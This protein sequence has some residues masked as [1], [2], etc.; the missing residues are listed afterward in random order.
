MRPVRALGVLLLALTASCL[1]RSDPVVL[2][3][4]R[5]LSPAR[6]GAPAAAPALE[7][8]PVRL[9]EALQ[10]TQLVTEAGAGALAI[11]ERHRWANGLDR[12]V[13][14]VLAENLA[15]LLGSEA[16]VPF[17]DGERVKAAWRLELDVQRLDG[18]P[19]GTLMLRA[20]WMLVP[21]KGGAAA[22]RRRVSLD[23]PVGG[24][25]LESLAAAHDRILDRLSREIAA[26]AASWPSGPAPAAR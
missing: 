14:R 11:S 24:P 25:G 22:V 15:A 2:H 8:M 23:E 9:P 1:R 20:T 21:A 16:V 5:P 10:R 26:T 17:P 13:Q 19:G 6:E 7:V 18:R 4:L 3:V 12:D